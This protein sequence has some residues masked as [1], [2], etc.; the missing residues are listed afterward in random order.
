MLKETGMKKTPWGV[1]LFSAPLETVTPVAVVIFRRCWDTFTV[2]VISIVTVFG[3]MVLCQIFKTEKL[4]PTDPFFSQPILTTYILLLLIILTL[5]S[6]FI[7]QIRTLREKLSVCTGKH[8][9]LINTCLCTIK[10]LKKMFT[11]VYKMYKHTHTTLQIREVNNTNSTSHN[12]LDWTP[13]N[14]PVLRREA[15][16]MVPRFHT[17]AAESCCQGVRGG[18]GVWL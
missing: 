5:F 8:S 18:G 9:L 14:P 1:T 6:E 7:E 4:K 12:H 2:M 15:V 17:V 13:Q 10:S 16:S 3:C 11:Y